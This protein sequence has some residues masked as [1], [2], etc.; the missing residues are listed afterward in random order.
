MTE[1]PYDRL[2]RREEVERR[3]GLATTTIYRKMSEGTFPKP[4]RVSTRAVRWVESEIEKWI[5]E[6]PLA[7]GDRD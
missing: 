4:K 7:D 2:L 6:R 1:S 3:C 5:S